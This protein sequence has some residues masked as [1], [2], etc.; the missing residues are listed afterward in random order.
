M[1]IW[2]KTKTISINLVYVIQLALLP[3]RE[4]RCYLLYLRQTQS[5]WELRF[6]YKQ[7]TRFYIYRFC[8]WKKVIECFDVHRISKCHKTSLTFEKTI[9]KCKNVGVM[10]NSDTERKRETERKYFWKVMETVQELGR[11]GIPFQGD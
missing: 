5:K 9:P 11:Q 2:K 10:F 6:N 4:R 3:A 7:R 8:N 1:I